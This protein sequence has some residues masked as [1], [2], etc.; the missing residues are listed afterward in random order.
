MVVPVGVDLSVFQ[1]I[2]GP[3]VDDADTVLPKLGDHGHARRM[4]QGQER[5][6]G[7]LGDPAG[8][9]RL[10]GQ[11]DPAASGWDEAH[12]AGEPRPAARSPR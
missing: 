6:R 10:A 8:I 9:E 1:A 7:P 5:D 4:R 12:P 11:V 2:I 3:Q